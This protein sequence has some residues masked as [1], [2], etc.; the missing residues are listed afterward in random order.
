MDTTAPRPRGLLRATVAGDGQFGPIE[1][2]IGRRL[3]RLVDPRS[4][5]GR[6][7]LSSGSVDLLGPGGEQFG[8]VRP[9]EA[10]LRLRHSLERRLRDRKTDVWA[11]V[12][13]RL[14]TAKQELARKDEYDFHVVNLDVGEAVAEILAALE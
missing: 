7:L 12:D 10:L 13:R 11:E 5:E 14:E 1:E 6:S 9:T 2:R 8:C 4:D 3:M